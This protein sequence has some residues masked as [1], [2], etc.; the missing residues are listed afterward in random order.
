MKLKLFA[1]T[2]SKLEAVGKAHPSH[3]DRCLK[4]SARLSETVFFFAEIFPEFDKIL[5][6]PILRISISA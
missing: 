6:E 1:D 4:I 3:A 5:Q 2:L